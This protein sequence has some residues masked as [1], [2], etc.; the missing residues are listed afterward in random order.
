MQGPQAAGNM[1]CLLSELP[2]QGCIA[3]LYLGDTHFLMLKSHRNNTSS[4]LLPVPSL[5]DG[6]ERALKSNEGEDSRW[7]CLRLFCMQLIETP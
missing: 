4:P 3:S 7:A 2:S 5:E 6:L 1:Q